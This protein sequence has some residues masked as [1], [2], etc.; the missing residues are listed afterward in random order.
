MI[1]RPGI[2]FGVL[3]LF[4]E[5]PQASG[6]KT[7]LLNSSATNPPSGEPVNGIGVWGSSGLLADQQARPLGT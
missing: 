4:W 1:R 5:S 2:K 3:E 6:E 7:S